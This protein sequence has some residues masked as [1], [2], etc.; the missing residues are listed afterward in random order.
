MSE[1]RVIG[2]E[3]RGR[4]LR[5]PRGEAT[6]PTSSRAREALFGWLG[7]QTREAAVLDLFAGSGAL[8]IE[9]LSRGAR[10]AVFVERAVPA[11]GAL[12][13]NLNTLGLVACARVFATSVERAVSRLRRDRARFGLILADPPY[14]SSDLPDLAERG[15][16]AELLDEDGVLVVER[17]ASGAV[18]SGPAAGALWLRESRSYGRTAFDWYERHVPRGAEEGPDEGEA[19]SS[20]QGDEA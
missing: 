15:Q 16:L 7:E 2:G 1:L 14:R 17:A 5:T 3:L 10:S 20:E 4:R 8:G 9:A 6:R 18:L 11:L 12:R 13:E 19:E